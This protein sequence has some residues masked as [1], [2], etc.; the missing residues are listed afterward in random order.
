MNPETIAVL[1]MF[2]VRFAVPVVLLL[3][4]GA[5]FGASTAPVKG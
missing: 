3:A 2:L 5:R 1:I 4:L